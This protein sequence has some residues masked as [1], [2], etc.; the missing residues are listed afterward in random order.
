MLEQDDTG[1]ARLYQADPAAATDTLPRSR[2][3]A[4]E[5]ES[6]EPV[7]TIRDLAAAGIR[8]LAK[9]LIADLGP[10]VPR[11]RRDAF[12][13]DGSGGGA[14]LK[15]EGLAVLDDRRIMLVNDNDFGVPDPQSP[16]PRSCLWVIEL[17][18]PL[19]AHRSLTI[20]Q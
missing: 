10:L 16:P 18:S 9:R 17:P 1:L 13:G 11:L 3:A 12:G 19:P 7:E 5:N 15:L 4:G 14:R 2:P 6:V 20:Q 8:P